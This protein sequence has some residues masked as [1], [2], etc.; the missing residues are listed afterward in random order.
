[1]QSYIYN[2]LKNDETLLDS[3][4][5]AS[6]KRSAQGQLNCPLLKVKQDVHTRWNSLLTITE[7]LIKIK[8]LFTIAI[9]SLQYLPEML[10][11]K[12]WDVVDW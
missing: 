8:V 5:V 3:S 11:A 1:M 12:E 6:E 10:T 9:N 7:T 4:T 2:Y